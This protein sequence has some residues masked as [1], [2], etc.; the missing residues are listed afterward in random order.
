M[1][2]LF[3]TRPYFLSKKGKEKEK[4]NAIYC[5]SLERSRACQTQNLHAYIIFKLTII[6]LQLHWRQ[7]DNISYQSS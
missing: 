5:Y 7:T 3:F 4:K 2:L 6:V 1:T